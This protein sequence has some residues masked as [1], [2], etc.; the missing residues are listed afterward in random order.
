LQKSGFDGIRYNLNSRA[1]A[2]SAR[3]GD[4]TA[5]AKPDLKK[6]PVIFPVLRE[7]GLLRRAAKAAP[8]LPHEV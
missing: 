4:R 7:S 2:K 1:V 8:R 5:Q 3:P 6:F